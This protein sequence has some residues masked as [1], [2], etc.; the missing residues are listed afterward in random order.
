[1]SE[2]YKDILKNLFEKA[3]IGQLT[4]RLPNSEEIIFFGSVDGPECD[5]TIHD[6]QVM[7]MLAK[8]GDIGFG[9]AYHSGFWDSSNVPDLLTYCS[10]N[11]S[12]IK[13]KGQA[14]YFN[15]IIFY[16]HNKLVRANTLYGSKRNI[17]EHYDIG[18]DFYQSWLDPT[19]TYSS[20]I[21]SS[22]TDSLMDAQLNKYQRI[23]NKINV[24]NNK[25]LEIGCG[26]GGFAEEAAA[27]GA[28]VTGLTISDE[29]YRYATK[30]L[31]M[32][33]QILME[34]YRVIKGKFDRIV[35]IEM[36]EAVG[37]KFWKTYFDQIKRLLKKNGCAMIQTITIDNQIFPEYRKKSDYIRHHVFPGGM[38]P[39]KEAFCSKARA[40]KLEIGEI[41]EF[42][43]DYAWTLQK[44]RENFADQKK[45][46][47]LNGCSESFLRSWEFYLSICI[48]GFNSNRTNVMQVEILN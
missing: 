36:F 9:E 30:R 34:D 33:A 7:N 2:R 31:N 37:E 18:N 23:I 25:I 43:Q 39:S 46:L 14:S 44:W 29:Q 13:N 32:D 10:L 28:H 48:A 45:R 19:M 20:A 3:N 26:W 22:E 12:S 4:I 8:R 27:A 38:L 40:S 1:M 42:G 41:F 11:L 21:R 15:K 17:L 35:S 24:Q 47:I 16:L 6:W 5:M